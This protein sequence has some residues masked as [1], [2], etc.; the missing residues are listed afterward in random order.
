[1]LPA[2]VTRAQLEVELAAITAWAGRAGWQVDV[3]PA[4][5]LVTAR[6]WHPRTGVPLWV[7]ADCA[8]Y[9]SVAPAWRFLDQAGESQKSAYP[10]AG[11]QPGIS[12]SVFHGNGLICAPWNRLAYKVNNGPHGDWGALT[13][14]KTAAAGYTQAHTIADM[15]QTLSVHLTAS[16]A[17]MT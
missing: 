10:A 2:L 13:A 16:P 11:Q 5:R 14:W 6:T 3:D 7:Q 9:P 17:M 4:G 15:L 12:G 8:G 1:M